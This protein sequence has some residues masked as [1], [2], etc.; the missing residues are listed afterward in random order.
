MTD[1]PMTTGACCPGKSVPG[2]RQIKV[3]KVLVG[4]SGLDVIFAQLRLLGREAG[5]EM[6]DELLDMARQ[7]NYISPNSEEAYKEA[8]LREYSAY[9]ARQESRS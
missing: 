9:C 1:K 4:M 7:H 2:V 5:P 6:A 8:L 3:G